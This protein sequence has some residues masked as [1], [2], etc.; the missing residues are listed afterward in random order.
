MQHSLS[1]IP[2][3]IRATIALLARIHA[4]LDAAPAQTA[5]ATWPSTTGPVTFLVGA[6]KA[7][8]GTVRN[9]LRKVS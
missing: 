2:A 4:E 5:V 8:R 9:P 3:G 6:P 7:R 1:A